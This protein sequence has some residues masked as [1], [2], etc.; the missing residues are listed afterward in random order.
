MSAVPTEQDMADQALEDWIARLECLG[1]G[2][3]TREIRQ[4]AYKLMGLMKMQVSPERV[5]EIERQRGLAR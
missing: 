5:R 4:E 1:R 2:G 3:P